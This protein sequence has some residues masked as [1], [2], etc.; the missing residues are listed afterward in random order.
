MASFTFFSDSSVVT[1]GPLFLQGLWIHN[2]D[3]PR[4]TVHNFLYGRDLRS[5]S[6]DMGGREQFFAGRRFPV[7]DFGEHD[8]DE[9]S[10]S[11]QV[12]HGPS[13]DEEREL[14]RSLSRSKRTL[15]FRDN[16]GRAVFGT[17]SS[18]SEED[19]SWGTEFSFT[20]TRVD[21]E[22]TFAVT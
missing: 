20:V 16:R 4:N 14:M 5:Y 1:G 19:A 21:R 6:R 11:L 17:I 9:Y 15:V 12:L 3:D 8:S 18:L 7:V 2:P 10:V 22:E 13:Y